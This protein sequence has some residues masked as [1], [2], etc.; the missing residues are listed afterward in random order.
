MVLTTDF[1][2]DDGTIP[3]DVNSLLRQVNLTISLLLNTEY[4]YHKH[5][6]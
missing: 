4:D 2:S 6:D 3:I 1:I 5:T